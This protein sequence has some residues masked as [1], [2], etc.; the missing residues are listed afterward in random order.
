MRDTKSPE[1]GPELEIG[2][3]SPSPDERVEVGGGLS[4]TGTPATKYPEGPIPPPTPFVGDRPA[5]ATARAIT[6]QEMKALDVQ[7]SAAFAYVYQHSSEPTFTGAGLDMLASAGQYFG[8]SLDYIRYAQQT[9]E[10]G[11]DPREHLGFLVFKV[12]TCAEHLDFAIQDLEKLSHRK[13]KEG[14]TM[15]QPYR[16]AYENAL[17]AR[18]VIDKML[19]LANSL[20]VE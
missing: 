2:P 18:P 7:F 17:Q 5:S 12:K 19:N 16:S 9:M 20:G 15:G 6:L 1:V 14:A 3:Q 13:Q 4:K 8:R 10:K 11:G